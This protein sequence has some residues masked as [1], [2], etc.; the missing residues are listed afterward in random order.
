MMIVSAANYSAH[1]SIGGLAGDWYGYLLNRAALQVRTATAT[2][3]APLGISPPQLR[4]LE[5]IAAAQPLNQAVLGEMVQMDRTTI[6]HL[7]DHFERLGAAC[8]KPDPTDRRSHA[9]ALTD[10]GFRILRAGRARARA[11][12]RDFLGP[13]SPSERETLRLL[14]GKLFHPSSPIKERKRE[15]SSSSS[16]A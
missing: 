9:I 7:V 10:E 8:R 11:V 3:L 1:R 4:A 13:L 16:D 14:L 2:A 5:A 12:E 6:V 15:P